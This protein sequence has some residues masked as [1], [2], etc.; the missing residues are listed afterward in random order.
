[1]NAKQLLAMASRRQWMEASTL[2]ARPENHYLASELM[3]PLEA[4]GDQAAAS[5]CWEDSANHYQAAL[6]CATLRKQDPNMHEPLFRLSGKL[7]A[8]M[9]EFMEEQIRD[10]NGPFDW[11]TG[12]A[13]VIEL[14]HRQR[15][16]PEA[17]ALLLRL[18]RLDD[19][20]HQGRRLCGRRLEEEANKLPGRQRDLVKWFCERALAQFKK[21]E[22]TVDIDRLATRLSP[23]P[24]VRKATPP[25]P[26]APPPVDLE[27]LFVELAGLARGRRRGEW[28]RL[29][30]SPQNKPLGSPIS[31]RFEAL[32]DACREQR[33]WF[34]A[35][36]FYRIAATA[37]EHAEA[38]ARRLGEKI[39]Q[40][41]LAT[42]DEKVSHPLLDN[43]VPEPSDWDRG[44]DL[45]ESLALAGRFAEADALLIRLEGVRDDY[46]D[47]GF[48]LP[49]RFEAI[50]DYLL[51]QH[52]ELARWFYERFQEEAGN[53]PADCAYEGYARQG[54]VDT[55]A[56]K[57]A[58]A[59]A[60][61]PRRIAT[62]QVALGALGQGPRPEPEV[63]VVRL[64]N[65]Q[66][67]KLMPHRGL[68]TRRPC[69]GG[70]EPIPPEALHR[71]YFRIRIEGQEL[72]L[73]PE[74]DEYGRKQP[75]AFEPPPLASACGGEILYRLQAGKSVVVSYNVPGG[76]PAWTL[77]L[78]DIAAGI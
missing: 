19:P 72:R 65:D 68:F 10:Q 5:R 36:E 24:P 66:V 33:E 38:A 43:P 61:I 45:A 26:P 41:T 54:V 74:Q 2:L 12:T 8:A 73:F 64:E 13:R 39:Q 11:T 49:G 15:L 9:R 69:R 4:L 55:A 77:T 58:Q 20:D 25:R 22:S 17:D 37:G 21:A 62:L 57:V 29:L 27:A 40:M 3:P 23:P 14:A 56:Y 6:L 78:I 47:R 18:G 76:G 46:S 67:L 51:P 32:A 59:N 53:L 31:K 30:R 7:N 60:R 34:P 42:I 1:M 70:S 48:E 16:L 50:G 28:H 35:S 71:Y 44:W 52:P 63:D 75:F